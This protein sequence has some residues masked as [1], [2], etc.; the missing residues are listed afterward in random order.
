MQTRSASATWWSER[1]TQTPSSS[2]RLA[3]HVA[4]PARLLRIDAGERLVADE[5]L[6]RPRQGTRELEPA[7]LAA[8]ELAGAHVH[9]IGERHA[10][11]EPRDR[12]VLTGASALRPGASVDDA[13]VDA[14]I[15]LHRQVPE[16]ARGLRHVRNPGA[17][18]LPERCP[19]HVLAEEE[20]LP[21]LDGDLA[22]ER[23]EQ[24]RLAGARRAEHADD[25][26]ACERGSRR[27]AGSSCRRARTRHAS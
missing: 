3:E 13:M 9:A 15:V 8:G 11:G 2:A 23:P 20:D 24:R 5:H 19:R 10:L 21:V 27:R 16:D 4:E 22:D 1:R 25:L 7:S 12:V 14:E 6:R 26:T 18:A 17:R